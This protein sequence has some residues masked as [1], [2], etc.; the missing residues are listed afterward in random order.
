MKKKL[1]SRLYISEDLEDENLIWVSKHW[2]FL[3]NKK[4]K[5]SNFEVLENYTLVL[6]ESN[7]EF[8]ILN[9]K[10]DSSNTNIFDYSFEYDYPSVL[11]KTEYLNKC[12]N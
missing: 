12:L 1:Y 7:Q 5:D 9:S 4:P 6:C 3:Y 8:D 2:D 11:V 10:I